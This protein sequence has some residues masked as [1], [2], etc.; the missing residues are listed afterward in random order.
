MGI[1]G[2]RFE[3][4]PRASTW[5]SSQWDPRTPRTRWSRWAFRRMR[6]RRR[7]PSPAGTVISSVTAT[8]TTIDNIPPGCLAFNLIQGEEGAVE[9]LSAWFYLST[10]SPTPISANAYIPRSS[11]ALSA[12][13]RLKLSVAA[14]GMAQT[15]GPRTR[16]LAIP[17]SSEAS[18][19][20]SARVR[21]PFPE[22]ATKTS[23]RSGC[24]WIP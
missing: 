21:L 18:Y 14:A 17:T 13:G 4:K 6:S 15:R 8:I 10:A 2:D 19:S 1:T 23:G 5:P 7:T 11:S 3:G 12:P 22:H 24:R 20:T 16:C 9:F